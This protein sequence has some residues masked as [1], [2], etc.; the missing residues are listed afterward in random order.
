M[1]RLPRCFT[2]WI[3]WYMH[4]QL[5]LLRWNRSA[6]NL[7]YFSLF[8]RRCYFRFVVNYLLELIFSRVCCCW[9]FLLMIVYCKFQRPDTS[10]ARS[11]LLMLDKLERSRTY[12][13][14]F[15][16]HTPTKYHTPPSN[17]NH[18]PNRMRSV[19]AAWFCTNIQLEV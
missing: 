9:F 15:G 6:W 18:E 10:D 8:F 11:S 12:T 16:H 3:S 17:W 13:Y 1:A 2:S 14:Y 19:N 7:V 4:T 5:S